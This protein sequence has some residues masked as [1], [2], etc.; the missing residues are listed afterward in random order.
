[1]GAW[2]VSWGTVELF[3]LVLLAASVVL[4][5]RQKRIQLGWP[6]VEGQVF[7]SGEVA[8][9]M[10]FVGGARFAM[11][12]YAYEVS[13]Q[14]FENY[15][16]ASLELAA[17]YPAGATFLVHYNP[18]APLETRLPFQ[19]KF[20]GAAGVVAFFAIMFV[21]FGLGGLLAPFLPP[22]HRTH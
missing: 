21:L 3:G 18:S 14:R 11:I 4:D 15:Y 13:S 10:R 2:F 1:M 12:Q 8:R 7:W 20:G 9:A 6:T 19:R 16:N 22:P 5:R 17:R